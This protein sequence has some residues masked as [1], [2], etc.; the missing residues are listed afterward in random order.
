[1]ENY[2][3]EGGRES[4]TE[5]ESKGELWNEKNMER[6]TEIDNERKIAYVFISFFSHKS[7][8]VLSC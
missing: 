5:R 3:R 8:L 4:E 6:E 2:K 7:S 1:M